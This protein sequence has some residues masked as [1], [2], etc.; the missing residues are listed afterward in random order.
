MPTLNIVKRYTKHSKLA[1]IVISD[2]LELPR[3][4][5]ESF[6]TAIAI[7][8]ARG[9]IDYEVIDYSWALSD[10]DTSTILLNPTGGRTGKL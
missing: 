4:N 7:Q 10:K 1:G 8:S 6:L 2:K 5:L 3:E 9:V